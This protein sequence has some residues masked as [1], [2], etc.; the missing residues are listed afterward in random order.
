MSKYFTWCYERQQLQQAPGKVDLVLETF[1][2]QTPY[3]LRSLLT[4]PLSD[5]Q[6]H[7]GQ[8]EVVLVKLGP[9]FLQELGRL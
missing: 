6:P 9:P 2:R 7:L 8:V 4:H 1:W 3:T 5:R